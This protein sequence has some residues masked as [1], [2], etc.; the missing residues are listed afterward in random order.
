M[1]FPRLEDWSINFSTFFV[2]WMLGVSTF[3][4]FSWAG[5]V[6]YQLFQLYHWLEAWSI[7][8]S[9]FFVGWRLGVSIF[10]PFSQAGGL[11]Y[12]LFYPCPRLEVWSIN[13]SMLFLGW[14]CG[15]LTFLSFSRAGG[16]EYQLFL[17]FQ[18]WSQE[19][20]I[21]LSSLNIY[22]ARF[23]NYGRCCKFDLTPLAEHFPSDLGAKHSNSFEL[24]G[25]PG[26][27]L[28][29]RSNTMIGDD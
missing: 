7:N 24:W 14:T 29:W 16:L 22:R 26:S 12:Q 6:E 20:S 23:L 13:F 8:C 9:T 10:L 11:G 18:G 21:F 15:V 25:A 1:L 4:S 17:L 5:G 2:G 28:Y 3:P 27:N 19:V